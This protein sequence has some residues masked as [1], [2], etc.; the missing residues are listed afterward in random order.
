MS[1]LS[2][3]VSPSVVT[4]PRG[5]LMAIELADVP[6]AVSRIFTVSAPGQ[7]A[8]RGEHPAECNEHMVLVSGRVRVALG[9]IDPVATTL[10]RPGQSLAIPGGTYIVYDLETADTVVLVLADQPWVV[11]TAANEHDA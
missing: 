10:E 9:A 6:F 3:P 7:P 11:E 8:R 5:T 1:E 2:I 4:D